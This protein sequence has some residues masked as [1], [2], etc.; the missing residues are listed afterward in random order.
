LKTEK[1]RIR[2]DRS[3]SP[4]VV[5][6]RL[7]WAPAGGVSYG[8]EHV[9]L[10]DRTEPILPDEVPSLHGVCGEVALGITAV[11]DVGSESDMVRFS[12]NIH[13]P[14]QETLAGSLRTGVEG[15]EAPARASLLVDDLRYWLIGNPSVQGPEQSGGTRDFY[16]MSR[17]VEESHLR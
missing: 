11:N 12:V 7:Y 4:S 5:G 3:C 13:S 2:W 6:Y 10:G 15:W 9:D 17:H 16:F 14:N 8:S 1:K